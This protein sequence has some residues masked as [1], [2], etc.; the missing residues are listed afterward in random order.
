MSKFTTALV[1]F[2]NEVCIQSNFKYNVTCTV[3]DFQRRPEG[4]GGGG[5]RS[6]GFGSPKNTIRVLN[7]L[8]L[9]FS[10]GRRGP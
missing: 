9:H 6:P 2:I 10:G 5:N 7:Y 8:V 3:H 4:G 1:K